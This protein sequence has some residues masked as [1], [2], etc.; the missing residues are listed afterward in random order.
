VSG[1]IGVKMSVWN[2]RRRRRHW[3]RGSLF[4]QLHQV[5]QQRNFEEHSYYTWYGKV[6]N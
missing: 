5:N 6:G 4:A 1:G 3:S 2:G